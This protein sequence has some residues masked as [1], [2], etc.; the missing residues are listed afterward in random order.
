MW[1]LE[2]EAVLPLRSIAVETRALFP[3][4]ITKVRDVSVPTF[5]FLWQGK[6][7]VFNGQTDLEE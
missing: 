3:H 7:D 6:V 5:G 2:R 4:H 1:L